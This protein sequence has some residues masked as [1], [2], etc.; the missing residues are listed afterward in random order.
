VVQISIFH[1]Y[2][3]QKRIQTVSF[4]EIKHLELIQKI[5]LCVE[6]NRFIQVSV[7]KIKKNKTLNYPLKKTKHL[8]LSDLFH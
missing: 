2:M 3:S 7:K 1:F 6:K 4:K 5:W 8:E